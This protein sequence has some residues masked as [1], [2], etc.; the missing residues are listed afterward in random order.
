MQRIHETDIAA[1]PQLL[2]TSII[3]NWPEDLAG[4]L[5]QQLKIAAT[6]L[7]GE[8]G[9]KVC[10]NCLQLL[11]EFRALQANWLVATSATLSIERICAYSNNHNRFA[12]VLTDI[13]AE[14][15][16]ELDT[17]VALWIVE[18]FRIWA[19]LQPFWQRCS[20]DGY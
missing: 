19:Y 8:V 3:T 14:I 17:Y 18:N 9:G 10:V 12:N 7:P 1:V 16:D 6:Q 2:D 11:H 5:R 4:C 13:M 20:R 15:N